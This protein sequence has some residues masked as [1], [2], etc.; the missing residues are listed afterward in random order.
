MYFGKCRKTYAP[1]VPNVLPGA[2][3]SL[4]AMLI[5]AYL[6]TGMRMSIENVS[7]T[8]K[9]MFCITIS[10][11]EVQDILYQISN[12]LGDEYQLL[13]DTIRRAQLGTWTQHHRGRMDLTRICGCS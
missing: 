3:L 1:N 4:R 12:A 10:E 9:E 7:T 5:T 11:V 2:R 6:K 8:M 13:I